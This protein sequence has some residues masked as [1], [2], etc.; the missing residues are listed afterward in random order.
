MFFIFFF[1]SNKIQIW[2]IKMINYFDLKQGCKIQ[3]FLTEIL[4][5]FMISEIISDLE[6]RFLETDPLDIGEARRDEKKFFCPF[7]NRGY[8]QRR[9]MQRHSKEECSFRTG[10][11]QE[12]GVLVDPFINTNRRRH[13]NKRF[14]CQSCS[15]GFSAK[16]SLSRHIQLSCKTLK[17]KPWFLCFYCNYRSQ[18]KDNLNIHFGQRH[19]DCQ[20]KFL[21]SDDK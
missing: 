5:S 6:P 7:C 16:R 1:S 3:F 11:D 20:V 19:P 18:R 2:L 10:N 4:S 14:M 15:K 17:C 8:T 9:N 12:P 21:I 13:G